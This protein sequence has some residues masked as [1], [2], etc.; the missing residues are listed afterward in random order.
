L[1]EPKRFLTE[2]YKV[3]HLG[4]ETVQRIQLAHEL[5]PIDLCNQSGADSLPIAF[6]AAQRDFQIMPLGEV[7]FVQV[8]R[9]AAGLANEKILA[10]VVAKIGG[11]DTA[12]PTPFAAYLPGEFFS[13]RSGLPAGA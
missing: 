12:A 2:Q 9:S 11:H 3:R 1:T 7:V 10:A 8:Q 13:F 6:R 4:T 5:L